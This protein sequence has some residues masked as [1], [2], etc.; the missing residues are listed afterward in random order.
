MVLSSTL[1]TILMA[2]ASPHPT[3]V[4]DIPHYDIA[5][6]CDRALG[7]AGC[8]EVEHASLGALRFWWRKVSDQAAKEYCI[9]QTS[10][11]PFLNYTHLMHCIADK[12]RLPAPALALDTQPG[13][14]H[15]AS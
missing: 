2:A 7:L 11:A 10:A 5:A 1:L 4:V 12:A 13:Q 3:T 15:R 14:A 8:V 9:S 6:K